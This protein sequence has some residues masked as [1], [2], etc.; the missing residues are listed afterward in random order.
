MTDQSLWQREQFPT[1]DINLHCDPW[2]AKG[3]YLNG[4]TNHWNAKRKKPLCW[5]PTKRFWFGGK[6]FIPLYPCIAFESEA[7]GHVI[8]RTWDG[9]KHG[10]E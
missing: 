8:Q 7:Y 3:R 9:L 6:E 2:P 1:C 4:K 5:T 10:R